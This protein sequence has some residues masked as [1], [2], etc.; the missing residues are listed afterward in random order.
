[1]GLYEEAVYTGSQRVEL[2]IFP[3]QSLTLEQIF[4]VGELTYSFMHIG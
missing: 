2:L 3:G 1:M 4:A